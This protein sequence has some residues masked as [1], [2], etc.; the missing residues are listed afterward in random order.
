LCNNRIVPLEIYRRHSK[1]CPNKK[2]RYSLHATPSQ[3]DCACPLWIE[4]S[5]DGHYRRESLKT[6]NYEKAKKLRR[7]IEQ[8]NAPKPSHARRL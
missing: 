2:N 5:E 1:G 3:P 7:K 6:R 8:P 4:G